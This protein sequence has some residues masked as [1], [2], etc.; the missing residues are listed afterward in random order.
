MS[1]DE[2]FAQFDRAPLAS[3]SIGQA[4]AAVLHDGTAVVVKVRRPGVLDKVDVD[5]Q[6]LQNLAARAQRN[7]QWAE[8]FDFPA[9]VGD[10]SRTLREELDYGL[11]A[12][13]AAQFAAMFRD[14][15]GVHIP[16]V[17]R[18]LSS[19]HVLTIERMTGLRVDQPQVLEQNGVEVRALATR[20]VEMNLTMAFDHGLFHADPHPGNYFIEQSGRIAVIDFGMV[21]R[22]SSQHRNDL[23]A[24]FVAVDTGDS[25][26]ASDVLLR[27]CRPRAATDRDAL[28]D[29]VDRLVRRYYGKDLASLRLS[30]I[31]GDLMG[32]LRNRHLALPTPYALLFKAWA[33]L[34]GTVARLDPHASIAT[35]ISAHV[36]RLLSAQY[37]P[38]AM[39]GRVAESS[40]E[41]AQIGIELP[42]RAMRLL[43]D[44]ERGTLTLQLQPANT[45][46]VLDRLERL[47]NRLVTAAI[48]SALIIGLAILMLLY[49][50][51][52]STRWLGISFYIAL[53]A[54]LLFGSQLLRTRLRG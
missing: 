23:A 5:L 25:S 32:V 43:D 35:F 15:P 3:A 2:A 41:A 13:N 14:S 42:R 51:Y 1:I 40:L 24:F 54:A 16:V 20:L 7:R 12:E 45:D 29:D 48:T 30:E 28:E 34:E 39:L 19:A 6:I 53:G 49:H 26:R 44:L 22:L 10:F 9:L 36:R 18:E 31:L 21:G 27:L 52:G 37:S 50:P 11:E 4:H 47:T 38:S 33:M 17:Y 46:E 8:Q